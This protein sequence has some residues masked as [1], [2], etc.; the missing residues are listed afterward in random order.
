MHMSFPF[1]VA[2]LNLKKDVLVAS[3]LALIL[4]GGLAIASYALITEN[5]QPQN[6][7]TVVDVYTQKGGLGANVSGGVFEPSDN[8]V[9]YAYLTSEGLPMNDTQVTFTAKNSEN[10]VT[11]AASTDSSGVAT[12]DFI[13][14][15]NESAIGTWNVLAIANAEGQS[16]NDTLSFKCYATDLQLSVHTEKDGLTT[17]VF[18]P[19]DNVSVVALL[20]YRDMPV[21][22]AQ[23]DFEVSLPNGTVF[24]TESSAT[25]SSGIATVKFQIPWP[26]NNVLGDWRVAVQGEAFK[27]HLNASSDFE[28]QLLPMVID[29]FTDKGGRGQNVPDGTFMLNDTV[30]LY[31]EIRD[32]LNATMAD[33]VVGLTVEKQDGMKFLGVVALTNASGI[34]MFTFYIPLDPSLVGTML[35]I[36]RAEFNDTVIIDSLTFTVEAQS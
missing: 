17:A 29:V 8:V 25:D 18:V 28:C 2:E 12:V 21:V 5:L 11:R 7:V 19:T 24:L 34:A 10:E 9:L 26:S 13:L 15:A 27:Q 4:C 32:E 16:V 36:A 33:K 6:R 31:A 3:V 35:V 23:V 22:G 20:T 14:P 1:L 30:Y